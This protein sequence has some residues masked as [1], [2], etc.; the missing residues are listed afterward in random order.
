M[1]LLENLL[2]LFVLIGAVVG[3][4]RLARAPVTTRRLGRGGGVGVTLVCLVV[5]FRMAVQP[6]ERNSFVD[7]QE[8][9]L[10]QEIRFD[11]L[12]KKLGY[13]Y[14]IGLVAVSK[15]FPFPGLAGRTVAVA[16]APSKF[17]VEWTDG[18]LQLSATKPDT[19]ETVPLIC[20]E[21]EVLHVKVEYVGELPQK[22]C[23]H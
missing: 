19:G 2:V 13:D 3:L 18:V 14:Q 6:S 20:G 7:W 16:P 12:G 5:M 22:A 15:W 9:V 10:L 11:D 21:A 17:R 8:A 1:K 4:S 23:L